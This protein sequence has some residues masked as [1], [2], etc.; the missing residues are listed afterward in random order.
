MY[1]HQQ[2]SYKVYEAK[3][4]ITEMRNSHIHNYRLQ[5]PSQKQKTSRQKSSKA[6]ETLNAIKQQTDIY[7]IRH[8]PTRAESIVFSQVLTNHLPFSGS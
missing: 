1:T 4:G 7:K 3:A 2:Q 5:H 6:I 8:H